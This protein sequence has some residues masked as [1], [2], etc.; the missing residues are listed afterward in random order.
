[1]RL[2]DP[3]IGAE[4][5]FRLANIHISQVS[6]SES[7]SAHTKDPK[8]LSKFLRQHL[9]DLFIFK[10]AFFIL[11]FASHSFCFRI[12]FKNSCFKCLVSKFLLQNPCFHF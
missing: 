2:I 3:F 11:K 1:M 12:L 6:E 4:P 7:E 5:T 8:A 10:L 9:K